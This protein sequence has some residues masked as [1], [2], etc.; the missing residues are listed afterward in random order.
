ML[1]VLLMAAS[2]LCKMNSSASVATL[3]STIFSYP[4]AVSI[5]SIVEMGPKQQSVD[6]LQNNY[7]KALWFFWKHKAASTLFVGLY[8]TYAYKV[9]PTTFVVSLSES[10]GSGDTRFVQ[11]LEEKLHDIPLHELHQNV[12]HLRFISGL[13]S[14]SVAKGLK[15]VN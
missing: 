4:L 12:L 11:V 5:R 2:N 8:K 7:R 3:L 15:N 14:V 10:L 6:I 9:M 1:L 13:D